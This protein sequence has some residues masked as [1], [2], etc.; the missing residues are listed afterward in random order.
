MFTYMSTH[1][2]DTRALSFTNSERLTQRQTQKD[3]THYNHW[4]LLHHA[5]LFIGINFPNPQDA[6]GFEDDLALSPNLH[7]SKLRHREV[8]QLA[9][10]N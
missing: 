10:G 1:A 8:K 5:K 3:N 6:T 4:H 7:A 9:L 2:A